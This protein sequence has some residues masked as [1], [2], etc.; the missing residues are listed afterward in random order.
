[1]E[2]LTGK[3]CVS[4]RDPTRWPSGQG[5]LQDIEGR[6]NDYLLTFLKNNESLKVVSTATASMR[7]ER[8]TGSITKAVLCNQRR[9]EC[10]RSIYE[11]GSFVKF[12]DITGQ[13]IS[14]VHSLKKGGPKHLFVHKGT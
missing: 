13:N 8:N 12:F 4:L 10:S 11:K 3:G 5:R 1:M 14:R 6:I 7:Y 2:I 9:N